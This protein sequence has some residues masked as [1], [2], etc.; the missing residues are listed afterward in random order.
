MNTQQ[1]L[2]EQGQTF[3]RCISDK[4]QELRQ[5]RTLYSTGYCIS[6]QS[7]SKP[8]SRLSHYTST[9]L[10]HNSLGMHFSKL[11]TSDHMYPLRYGIKQKNSMEKSTIVYREGLRKQR[12]LHL[13]YK[14]I[15]VIWIKAGKPASHTQK[16]REGEKKEQL[17]FYRGI[18]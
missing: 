11:L 12:D 10:S 13:I 5:S 1:K 9:D 7:S 2:S 17:K 6:A 14:Q 16:V 15:P 18:I 3:H 4:M 8:R